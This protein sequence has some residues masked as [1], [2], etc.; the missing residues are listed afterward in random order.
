MGT[1]RDSSNM[2]SVIQ[3]IL[4]QLEY[5]YDLPITDRHAFQFDYIS[6][7]RDR[8]YDTLN[9]LSKKDANRKIII[10]LDSIDQLTPGDY[11][12]Q[13]MLYKL[14][15]NV[16]IIYSALVDYKGIVDRIKKN[17]EKYQNSKNILEIGDIEKKEARDMLNKWFTNANRQLTKAQWGL[18]DDVLNKTDRIYPLHLKLLFDISVKWQSG[19]NAVTSDHFVACNTIKN[20]IK[21]LFKNLES[22]FGKILFS[23]CI[24]YLTLLEYN[25][26]SESELEDIMSID[27]DVLTSVFQY[28]HPPLRRFPLALWIRIKYELR[29][30]ITNKD[31]DSVPVVSWF[32]RA[33]IEASKEYYQ[34]LFEPSPT[35]DSILINIVDYFRE[36]WNERRSDGSSGE[37][38]D[39]AYKKKPLYTFEHKKN[40]TAPTEY[41]AFRL[42]KAQK[43]ESEIRKGNKV[44]KVYN[45]RMLNEF[46]GIILMFH[47]NNLKVELLLKHV[48]LNYDFIYT[49]AVLSQFDFVID[50][51]ET[52]IDLANKVTASPYIAELVEVSRIYRQNH[53]QFQRYPNGLGYSLLSRLESRSNVVRNFAKFDRSHLVLQCKYIERDD[54]LFANM[55]SAPTNNKVSKMHWHHSQPLM[56]VETQNETTNLN[57]GQNI[58]T[59]LHLVDSTTTKSIRQLSLKMNADFIQIYLDKYESETNDLEGGCYFYSKNSAFFTDVDNN[60]FKLKEFQSAIVDLV[61]LSKSHVMCAL[62]NSIHIM[63]G[64]NVLTTET[65]GNATIVSIDSTITKQTIYTGSDFNSTGS[66]TFVIGQSDKKM[67]VYK[68]SS[69]T[70]NLTKYCEIS[71]SVGIPNSIFIDRLYSLESSLKSSKNKEVDAPLLRFALIDSKTAIIEVVEV[72]GLNEH[73]FI[74]TIDEKTFDSA[75]SYNQK[76]EEK[77]Q[78]DS[79]VNNKLIVKRIMNTT[80]LGVSEWL[81]IWNMCIYSLGNRIE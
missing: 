27:D 40:R 46:I 67:K 79:F 52:I 60:M 20:T 10:F 23:R 71:N 65:V 16:K 49:K 42:T 25:G 35:K 21:Y 68:F 70:L 30:Y 2:K 63:N 13:W 50:M 1:S 34:D 37:M 55:F 73:K 36:K 9:N 32:H 19:E 72:T 31:M 4:N 12:L 8:F 43:I 14:P 77:L 18:I 29:D 47:D 22:L 28:H 78:F 69:I 7:L 11:N 45:K 64:N 44:V 6:D 59:T 80:P 24:F 17:F 56:G 51:H 33:F 81:E 57:D 58:W 39:F 66:V 74:D 41:T 5:I 3:S 15:K 26:I 48:Y 62:T 75:F 61:M 76:P 38:K 53:S 54:E